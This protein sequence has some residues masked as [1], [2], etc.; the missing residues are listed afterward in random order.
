MTANMEIYIAVLIAILTSSGNCH[1]NACLQI[2][3]EQVQSLQESLQRTE[4][5][6]AELPQTDFEAILKALDVSSNL[7]AD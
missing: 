7:F 6:S 5:S 3:S 1:M 4:A 2:L